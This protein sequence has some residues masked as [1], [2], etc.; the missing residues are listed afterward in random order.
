M[1]HYDLLRPPLPIPWGPP[2]NPNPELATLSDYIVLYY[3]LIFITLLFLYYLIH[4]HEKGRTEELQIHHAKETNQVQVSVDVCEP[5][6]LR[7]EQEGGLH[8]EEEELRGEGRTPFCSGKPS[9]LL[10]LLPRQTSC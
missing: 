6:S 2:T 7:P 5:P 8:A 9:G 4:L 1:P 10:G 3:S